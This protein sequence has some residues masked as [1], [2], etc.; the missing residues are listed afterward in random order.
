MDGELRGA[1]QAPG[2]FTDEAIA[3]L[4]RWC[5]GTTRSPG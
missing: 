1:G 5:S 2:E 4:N 3:A